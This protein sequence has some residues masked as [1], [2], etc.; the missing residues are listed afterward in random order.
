MKKK[1]AALK[2]NDD[3]PAPKIIAQGVEGIA[4]LIIKTAKE[5]GIYIEKNSYLVETLMQFDVGDYI[6]EEVYQVVAQLLAFVY[7]LNLG[8]KDGDEKVNG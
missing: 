3:E 4:D 6:P 1:A 8:E 7:K 2:Y 5:N